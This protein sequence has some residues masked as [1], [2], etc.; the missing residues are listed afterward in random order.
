MPRKSRW[1]EHSFDQGVQTIELFSWDY[2]G[3]YVYDELLDY[4]TYVFRGHRCSN[5]ILESTLDRLLK[6]RHGLVQENH[7]TEQLDRFKYA[8]RGR[9]GNNP[10][11]L[12]Q[13]HDWWALGQHH[14]LSTPLL[15]WTVSPYVAAFFAFCQKKADDTPRRVIYALAQETVSEKSAE[16]KKAHLGS[17]R[18]PIIEFF[19][20]LSDE[21]ARLVNQG[22]L[23]TR[24]PAGVDI[25]KWVR[26]HFKNG[27]SEMILIKMTVP[28]RDRHRC[29][30]EL[31]RMN[32][33]HLTLFPDLYG[34]STFC[35]LDVEV[36]KY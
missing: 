25:E 4:K 30:R 18:P 19:K 12:S 29:L 7:V 22:G 33:N 34:A 8:A 16:L 1:V 31:N 36:D 24:A 21:N 9:R 26:Q 20:P 14:G 5:W 35:N 2:F 3:D 13:E 17:G 10:P 11:H 27:A 15:D 28:S 6:K 23:F 32:I